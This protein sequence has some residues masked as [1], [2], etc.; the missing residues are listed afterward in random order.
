MS[1][2]CATHGRYYETRG[3]TIYRITPLISIDPDPAVFHKLRELDEFS[4]DAEER[5][6]A[7]CSSPQT[8]RVEGMP[9]HSRVAQVLVDADYRMKKVSQGTVELP[10]RS[11][12]P[13]AYEARL[14]L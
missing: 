10:I 11:P 3:R 1:H 5:H 8:V 6:R 9:R 2:L 7:I 4:P 13:A 14:A 12:F